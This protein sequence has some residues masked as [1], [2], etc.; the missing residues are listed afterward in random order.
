VCALRSAQ[1]VC[2]VV[3]FADWEWPTVVP[4]VLAVGNYGGCFSEV[5]PEL[6][7]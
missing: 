3:L 1:A 7:F 6:L 4:G 5:E 2:V